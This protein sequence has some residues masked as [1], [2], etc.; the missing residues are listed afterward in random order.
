MPD[1]IPGPPGQLPHNWQDQ[2]SP[3]Q[4][5]PGLVARTH[6]EILHDPGLG[7]HFTDMTP[8]GTTPKSKNR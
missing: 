5:H 2:P 6:K 1:V 7:S 8:K 4:G 3:G